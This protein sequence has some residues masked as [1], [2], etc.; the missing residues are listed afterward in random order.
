MTSCHLLLRLFYR[1]SSQNVNK[2]V[3]CAALT[4]LPLNT[5]PALKDPQINTLILVKKGRDA[6]QNKGSR[7]E[8]LQKEQ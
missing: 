8:A 6:M 4:A 5:S 1:L 2:T 3:S 7:A